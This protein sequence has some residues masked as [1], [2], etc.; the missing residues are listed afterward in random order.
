[1]RPAGGA[2]GCSDR[3]LGCNQHA[4]RPVSLELYAYTCG[5][6]TIPRGFLLEAAEGWIT[7]PIP[8]YLIVH[9][10]GKVLF[11]SGLKAR[12]QPAPCPPSGPAAPKT[13]PF[14][15]A[16]RRGALPRCRAE[17]PA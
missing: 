9:P 12:P 4:E 16:P 5:F 1:M 2:V 8:S 3:R 10:A 6:L 14:P 15:S 17:P 7:V 11:D 13:P